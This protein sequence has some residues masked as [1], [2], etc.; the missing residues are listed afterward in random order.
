M[1]RAQSRG[2]HFKT[3]PLLKPPISLYVC[4]LTSLFF[5]LNLRY[6]SD[7]KHTKK[8]WD[9]HGAKVRPYRGQFLRPLTPPNFYILGDICCQSKQYSIAKLAPPRVKAYIVA[10]SPLV[11]PPL[12]YELIWTGTDDLF[13]LGLRSMDRVKVTPLITF[14]DNL[15]LI[16][17]R[18]I[19]KE[20]FQVWAVQYMAPCTP[21]RL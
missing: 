12:D 7:V 4:M 21:S 2:C 11:R 15:L 20:A 17:R 19:G 16:D 14:I 1:F 5:Q 8:V 9:D 10:D 6:I 3:F 18:R 13:D